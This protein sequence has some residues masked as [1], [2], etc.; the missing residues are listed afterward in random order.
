MATNLK[1]EDALLN[2]ALRVSGFRTKRETVNEA[3]REY[4]TKRRQ[5]EV[6]ELEGQ[7]DFDPADELT[8]Q[9]K[10]T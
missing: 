2:E 3:L 4:V 6:L 9:R 7:I 1:I 5:R 10:R 8:K